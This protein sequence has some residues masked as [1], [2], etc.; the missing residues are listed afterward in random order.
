MCIP[1]RDGDYFI[2]LISLQNMGNY[3]LLLH[4]SVYPFTVQPPSCHPSFHRSSELSA[5]LSYYMSSYRL[6]IHAVFLNSLQAH[7]PYPEFIMDFLIYFLQNNVLTFPIIYI[8]TA[9][10]C[11]RTNTLGFL[12]LKTC[13]ICIK[14]M[15]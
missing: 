12:H 1:F 3:E 9:S 6:I 10:W 14:R 7:T 13:S 5:G 15:S 4:L 8:M 2:L 11:F